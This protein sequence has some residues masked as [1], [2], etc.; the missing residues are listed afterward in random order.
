MNQGQTNNRCG[1]MQAYNGGEM[2]HDRRTIRNVDDEIY[3]IAPRTH[4]RGAVGRDAREEYGRDLREKR[5]LRHQMNDL[6]HM[7]NGGPLQVVGDIF[8][9]VKDFL[10]DDGILNKVV[11]SVVQYGLPAVLMGA[12]PKDA[13]KYGAATGIVSSLFGQR[14][15]GQNA[16]EGGDNQTRGYQT[17]QEAI[18][19]MRAQNIP[20]D[21]SEF[22]AA[23]GSGQRDVYSPEQIQDFRESALTEVE[24]PTDTR[25]FFE[26]VLDGDLKQAFIPD[27]RAFTEQKDYL[28]QYAPLLGLGIGG[29]YLSGAFDPQENEPPPDPFGGQTWQ[30]LMRA[31]PNAYR[32]A[33]TFVARGNADGGAIKS[34]P[35]RNGAINGPGTGTSDDIPAMLSDGEFVM[36]A[37]S[38]LNAGNGDRE[39]GMNRMYD[40]MHQLEGR[41]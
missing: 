6:P 13:L 34:F 11:K 4:E 15:A 5:Y 8:T 1:I 21:L 33:P 3:R 39:L 19:A 18:D 20:G 40:A 10:N 2:S 41:A 17:E 38:V 37:Q 9:N 27:S 32:S 36:T 35:R 31:N 26:S 25:G 16:A 28:R 12:S 24:D 30:G 29:M 14:G 22:D 7:K 23:S